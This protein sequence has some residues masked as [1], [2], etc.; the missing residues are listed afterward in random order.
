MRSRSKGTPATYLEN[1]GLLILIVEAE[2]LADFTVE[3]AYD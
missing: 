1:N 3:R 2:D